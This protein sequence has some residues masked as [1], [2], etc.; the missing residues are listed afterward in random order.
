MLYWL[1]DRFVSSIVIAWRY[2]FRFVIHHARISSGDPFPKSLIEASSQPHSESKK[3]PF[4]IP[5]AGE[6]PLSSFL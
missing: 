4:Q 6:C 5:I 2:Q 3:L 1:C